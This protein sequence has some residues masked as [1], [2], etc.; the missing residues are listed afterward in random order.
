MTPLAALWIPIVL[1][2]VLV[3]VASSL[4]HMALPWHKGDYLSVPNEDKVLDALRPFGIAPGDYF[5]PKPTTMADMKSPAFIEKTNRGP[6]IVM[7]VMPN[8]MTPMGG[9]LVN[10]FIYLVVVSFV[11]AYVTG[12]ALGPGAAYLKVFQIAG[13]TGFAAYSLGLWQQNIWYRRSLGT[14]LRSTIDGLM[15]AMLTAGAFGWLWPR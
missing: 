6:K 1:G 12:R 15:Y 11:T 4:V 10:W 7:T 13:A 9:L 5:L 8:G 14:T 3:F 2:A